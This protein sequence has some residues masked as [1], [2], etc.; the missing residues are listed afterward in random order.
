MKTKWY[1]VSLGMAEMFYNWLWL[2]LHNT[3]NRWKT[4]ELYTLNGWTF[5][6]CKLYLNKAVKKKKKHLNWIIF[7]EASWKWVR[8]DPL[9]SFFLCGKSRGSYSPSVGHEGKESG[10]FC[11]WALSSSYLKPM[12]VI[13]LN[14]L[15]A[16]ILPSPDLLLSYLHLCS[17]PFS[18][19]D[20]TMV[21]F[22]NIQF[23]LY[24]QFSYLNA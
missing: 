4:I 11:P 19:Y 5:M 20:P 8:A 16:D 21:P 10:Q 6:A 15:C 24:T 12:H 2:W 7:Q 1:R 18:L 3:I 9:V 23:L 13:S 14:S 17:G 22:S